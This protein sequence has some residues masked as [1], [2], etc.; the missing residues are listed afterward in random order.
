MLL[1]YF[2]DKDEL[3]ISALERLAE[4]LSDMLAKRDLK[5]SLPPDRLIEEVWSAVREPALWPYMVLFTEVATSVARGSDN[6]AAATRSI[7]N[8]FR[9]WLSERLDIVDAEERTRA[10]GRI[11]ATIDGLALLQ[12]ADPPIASS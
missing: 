6:Y 10:A 3:I 5:G 1:Y 9:D 4:K 2:A 7:S 8:H 11:L 12:M